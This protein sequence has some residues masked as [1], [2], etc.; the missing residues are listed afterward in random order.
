MFVHNTL[1]LV[2]T[3][4]YVKVLLYVEFNIIFK[5]FKNIFVSSQCIN[6]LMH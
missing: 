5:C 1:M 6:K 4:R 2:Y 3:T